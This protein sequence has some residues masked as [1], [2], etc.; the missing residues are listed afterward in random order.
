MK[1]EKLVM[2]SPQYNIQLK[3]VVVEV[4]IGEKFTLYLRDRMDLLIIL[5]YST[6]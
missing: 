5:I 2:M 3:E 6:L 1:L 4:F